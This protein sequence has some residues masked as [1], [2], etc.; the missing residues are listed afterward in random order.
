MDESSLRKAFSNPIKPLNMVSDGGVHDYQSNYGVVIADDAD[1]FAK[2]LGK[3]YSIQ[4]HES[5]YRSEMYG[6]LAAIAS[7]RHIITTNDIII[8]QRKQLNIY[9]SEQSTQ[10]ENFDVQLTNT[11]IQ[12]WILNSNFYMS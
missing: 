5:S 10:D 3:I 11:D 9:R 6:L 2:N 4:F 1:T 7:L 8:P 12:T